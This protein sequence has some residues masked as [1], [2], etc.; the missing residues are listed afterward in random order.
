MVKSLDEGF[1]T[2]ISRLK[3]LNSEHIKSTIHH[4]T[5][6]AC[7][8]KNFECS[9]LFETW[10]FG[11]GTG[12]RHYSDTDYFAR[13][14][15]SK[16]HQNSSIS[17]RLI[18]EALQSTFPSTKWII[19]DSPAVKIPFGTYKS[20]ELEVTPCYYYDIVTT[21]LGNFNR[22][23]IPDWQGWWM[24]SS[25]KAHNKYVEKYDIRLLNR[26]KPLIQLIKAWKYYNNVPIM[27]F[28]L[29]LRIT[30]Y[31][32]SETYISYDIDLKNVVNLLSNVELGSIRDP[33]QISW[34]IPFHNLISQKEYAL[35][36][37][38]TAATRAQK[39]VDA[40]LAGKIDDAF[41]WWNL[42]FNNKFPPR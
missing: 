2:L 36:K 23:E 35:S 42:F 26:L 8:E 37:L 40:R 18:K 1:S 28:Y 14:P 22:Y 3:P 5:V 15:A 16:L 34:L 9:N 31:A 25:P 6:N 41:Y 20:E 4:S 19:V 10:S 21:S 30:K 11:N 24:Y 13:I 17:L 29:E 38:N 27:S 33:M 32:E 39:A 7:L 12:V